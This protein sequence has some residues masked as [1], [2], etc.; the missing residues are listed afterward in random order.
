MPWSR[1]I[2]D[3]PGWLA[4]LLD[5]P[6]KRR[7]LKAW[8]A[9]A[10]IGQ[11]HGKVWSNELRRQRRRPEVELLEPNLIIAGGFE[12]QVQEKLMLFMLQ[13]RSFLSDEDFGLLVTV[14]F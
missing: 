1:A 3:M 7:P 5:P 8:T 6:A 12:S 10:I 2:A 9:A 4:D 13:A 11:S 14:S